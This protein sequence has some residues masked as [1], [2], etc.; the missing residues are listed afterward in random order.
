MSKPK[1]SKLKRDNIFIL[2]FSIILVALL[3]TLGIMAKNIF[4]KEETVE[5][6]KVVDEIKDFDYKLTDHNTDYFKELFEELKKVLNEDEVDESKY[7]TLVAELFVT[8]FYDLN[9]KLSKNDVGGTQF[10][11]PKY[12]DT[13]IK[14]AT[15]Y[16][17]IYYYV[18][19]NL[20]GKRVQE[21]PVVKKVEVNS[22]T[23]TNYKYGTINDPK[24]YKATVQVT[25]EKDMGY[26]K[27]VNITMI[28]NE[29]KLYIVEI[30]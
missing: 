8:D 11:L 23:N 13:M 15:S 3:I 20:Y 2:I 10:I 26:Q 5:E 16:D 7:A 1:K 25:Y 14:K 4:T 12:K 9:S 28:H 21:L 6:A 22:L 30:K 24:A 18:K 17:G 27:T 19:S 29:E